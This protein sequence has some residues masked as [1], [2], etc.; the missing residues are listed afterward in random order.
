[1]CHVYL[2][3]DKEDGILIFLNFNT[4]FLKFEIA[5]GEFFNKLRNAV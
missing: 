2:D 5:V 3:V 4:C 1:M